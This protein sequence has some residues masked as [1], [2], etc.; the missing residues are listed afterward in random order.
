MG[1]DPAVKTGPTGGGLA[2]AAEPATEQ[3]EELTK[4]VAKE[5]A[6]GM[7]MTEETDPAEKDQHTEKG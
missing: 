1:T 3:A 5:P 7:D 6:V 4:E 2:T